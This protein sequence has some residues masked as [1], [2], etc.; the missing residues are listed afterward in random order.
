MNIL[1]GTNLFHPLFGGGEKAIID[2]LEDFTKLGHTVTVITTMPE[3]E[4][5]EKQFPFEVIRLTP[6]TP[7]DKNL[8]SIRLQSN[9]NSEYFNSY[10]TKPYDNN[11]YSMQLA[12]QK[13][14]NRNFD[15]Y[16]GYGKLGVYIEDENVMTFATLIKKENPNIITIGLT[17]EYGAGGLSWG[18]DKLLSCAPYELTNNKNLNQNF[19]DKLILIPKQNTFSP[20]EKFNYSEWKNRPYDFIFNNPQIGKGIDTLYYIIKKMKHK[21]FLLK[22]G[23]WG[24]SKKFDRFYELE[25]V[26]IVDRVES[27]EKDFFRKG[28]YLLYP[29]ILEGFGLMPLEGAMQGTIPICSDIGILRYSSAPF[30]VFVYSEYLTDTVYNVVS[31]MDGVKDLNWEGIAESWIDMIDFLDNN[32]EFVREKYNDLETVENYVNKRYEKTMDEF[33]KKL[34]NEC[35]L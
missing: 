10:S 12:S 33:L 2:W 8:N 6:K 26:D 4:G 17:W 25:N 19:Q 14:K 16:I 20:I 1:F 35:E 30:S 29:S 18:V 15:V 23:N 27:M 28:R 3:I 7:Y 32:Q 21:K 11:Y 9:S 31:E 34:A 24:D 13:I 22:H 5:Y